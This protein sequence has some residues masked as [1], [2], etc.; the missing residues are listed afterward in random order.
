MMYLLAGRKRSGNWAL[1][2][3]PIIPTIVFYSRCLMPE[4]KDGEQ[5]RDE[6]GLPIVRNALTEDGVFTLAMQGLS[7]AV[8]AFWPD[9]IM[10][11]SAFF[12]TAGIFQ[13]LRMRNFK[14]VILHTESPY[15]DDE[16]LMRGGLAHLNLLNDPANLE[17]FRGEGLQAEYMPH[18]YRPSVHYPRTGLVN[19]KLASDFC[20]I[21]TA[22]KSRIEFFERLNLNGIDTI[23]AGND[24]GKLPSTSP[25]AKYVATGIGTEADCVHNNEAADLYRNAKLGINTYR[26]EGESTHADDQAIAMGPREVEMSAIGLPFL[27]DKRPE[28]DKVLSMLPVF[29]SPEDASEKL[30]Y[31]LAHPLERGRVANLARRAIEDRTFVNNAKRLLKILEA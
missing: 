14:I 15:Q 1:K 31:W 13:L 7:H 17:M 9:V 26:R 10:F 20:F 12:T 24:W 22:F 4:Y 8:L 11:V 25:V 18:A 2:L 16:Q 23:I 30:R 28:G 19:P 6:Q 21:G 29:D 5:V 27:R 3:P